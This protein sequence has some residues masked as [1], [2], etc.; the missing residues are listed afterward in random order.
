MEKITI[1][2]TYTI[3]YAH[4][5]FNQMH[6]KYNQEC[7]CRNLHGHSGKIKVYIRA[8]RGELNQQGMVIDFNDLKPLKEYFD[9]FDHHT[10]ISVWDGENLKRFLDEEQQGDVLEKLR[11]GTSPVTWPGA[12][13]IV[14]DFIVSS[15]NLAWHFYL[16]AIELLSTITAELRETD[17]RVEIVR[18]EFSET[19]N[20]QVIIEGGQ[21]AGCCNYG[22]F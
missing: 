12:G 17:N 4:A 13:L 5:I 19:D 7:R 22:N 20:N 6:T 14:C 8:V 11:C 3:E 9:R 18:V 1:A 2:K 21:D 16:K 10:I 15:E